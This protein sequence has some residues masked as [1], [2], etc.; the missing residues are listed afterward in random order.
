[1]NV[2]AYLSEFDLWASF[3]DITQGDQAKLPQASREPSAAEVPDDA[4][5]RAKVADMCRP[6]PWPIPE[7]LHV[8]VHLLGHCTWPLASLFV[9]SVVSVSSVQ[10]EV[11]LR[12]KQTC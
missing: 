7:M 3:F 5:E 1:M 10:R 6:I 2:R 4:Y 8:H 12:P 11:S 9:M